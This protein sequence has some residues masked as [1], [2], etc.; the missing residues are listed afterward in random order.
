MKDNLVR[1]RFILEKQ[2]KMSVLGRMNV[3]TTGRTFLL[4][5]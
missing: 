5:L 2:E 3:M 4:F 1:V